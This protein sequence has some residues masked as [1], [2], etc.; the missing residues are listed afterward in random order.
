MPKILFS[1]FGSFGDVHPYMAIGL[2]LQSRGH[3][4]T[5]ATSAIHQRKIELA[6]LSFHPVR[7]DL[8]LDDEELLRRFYDRHRG[9]GRIIRMLDA[10]VRQTYEDS[11]GAFAGADLVVTH[12]V[13]FGGICAAEKLRKPWISTVLAP[14]SFLSAF[15]PPV[16]ANAPWASGLKKLGPGFVRAF[17]KIGR[18]QSR[19]WL[20]ET[21][22]LRAEVGLPAAPHPLFDGIHSPRAVLA[23]FSIHFAQQQPDWPAN[24]RITG[25]PFF[26]STN[27]HEAL[28]SE[29]EQFFSEG[30]SPVVFTL[31]SSAVLAAGTFYPDALEAVRRLGVRALLLT[32]PYSQGLPDRFPPGV[33]VADYA[34]HAAVFARA[35]VIVHQGGIGTTAQ[36]MRS[37][38]PMV[39]VP[40]AHDQ[41]DNADRVRRLG[42]A[43]VVPRYS[44]SA[45]RIEKALREVLGDDSRRKA[46]EKMALSIRSEQGTSAAADEIEQQLVPA[47]R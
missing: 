37:G 4:V 33:L 3:S 21:A 46:A 2:E 44:Y 20:R 31:G 28:A 25:F 23:L 40:F 17:F 10:S 5:I 34:P 26:S 8:S 19:S 27:E 42:L 43:S 6:G 22:R 11:L 9:S 30:E 38:R 16:F 35:S 32:G 15:D 1:T 45:A 47:L 41:F 39:V 29:I 18:A 14:F 12:I 24:T 7:P 36:A 13:S